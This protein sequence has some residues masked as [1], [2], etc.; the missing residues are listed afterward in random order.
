MKEGDKVRVIK[1]LYDEED[2]I[3]V[4]GL[5]G[6]IARIKY[7]GRRLLPIVSIKVTMEGFYKGDTLIF[8]PS[9]LELIK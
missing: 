5:E 4:V 3:D 9:E 1:N 7:G 2:L 6:V 8:F